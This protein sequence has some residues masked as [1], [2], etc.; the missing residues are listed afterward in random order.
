[1]SGKYV[2]IDFQWYRC[3][4][5]SVVPKE[6]AICDDDKRISHFVFR[7]IT[8]YASMS[9]KDREV[10]SYVFNN[11][12]GIKWDDGFVLVSEFDEIIRRFTRGVDVVYVKG[13][14]KLRFLKNIIGNKNV[15]DLK[16]ADKILPGVPSCMFHYNKWVVCAL[17]N[18]QKLYIYLRRIE[19][20]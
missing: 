7:P 9:V 3:S 6:L 12:H 14:E 11:C 20:S 15:V 5:E 8:S 17:S 19:L 16:E 2:I 1:M 18:V 4:G 13:Y 10:A